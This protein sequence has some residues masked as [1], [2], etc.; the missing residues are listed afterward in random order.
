VERISELVFLGNSL[1]QW[2]L[3]AGFIAGGFVVGKLCSW[4]MSGVLK[5]LSR[6]TKH[7]ID[8]I[9]VD[10]LEK[11][12]AVL[13]FVGGIALG[14][15]GLTLNEV[16]NL[17]SGRIFTI[18]FISVITWG[19][20]RLMDA[21]IVQYVPMK[22]SNLAGSGI[23][24]VEIQPILRKFFGIFLWIIAGALILRTLGYNVSALMAGL[25]LG[26]AAI[27][28]AS[29]DTL[30]NFFGSI[31]VFVDRPFRMHE[32]IKIAGYDGYI[33]EMGIRTSRLKTLENRTVIIPN[34]IFAANPSE[35]ISTEPNTKVSQTFALKRDNGIE[36]IAQGV[37][38]LK[39]IGVQIEGTAG[40]PSAGLVSIG[41]A[42][43]QITFVYYVAK[44]ADYFV[45][46]NA[47]NLEILRRFEEVGITLG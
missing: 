23:K 11:P 8:D 34:S 39:E 19:I 32:R 26:G 17:W 30:A 21:F 3:T 10:A 28:L 15:K 45:T 33:T 47:V 25:G 13:I 4:I 44:H 46:V 37:A 12:L 14:V 29:K 31:T 41:G 7:K 42:A 38:L 18:L 20:N 36:K 35:N 16:L 40:V 43:C 24:E 6:K 1:Q 27:A 9:V 2:F 5:R 22:S